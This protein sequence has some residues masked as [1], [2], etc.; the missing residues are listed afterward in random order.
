M[1]RIAAGDAIRAV[2][3]QAHRIRHAELIAAAF[4]DE[5]FQRQADA[6][7]LIVALRWVHRHCSAAARMT[8]DGQLSEAVAEFEHTVFDGAAKQMR[9]VWEH[10][11]KYIQGGG[12]LQRGRR[13]RAGVAEQR[14]LGVL[15]WTGADGSLGS[16][17]WAGLSVSL[18]AAVRAAET[19]YTALLRV[20]APHPDGVA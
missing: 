3:L 20:P 14:Q 18:D 13:R 17:H 16:L 2:A 8:G 19:L 6:R 7:F 15:T 5:G 1:V 11:D 10:F 4:A 12:Q 9:D